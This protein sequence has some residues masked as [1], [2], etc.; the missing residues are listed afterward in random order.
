MLNPCPAGP[1]YIRFQESLN[2]KNATEIDKIFSGKCSANQIF[3]FV[4]CLFFYK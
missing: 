1:G 4:R 2:Q 3:Q